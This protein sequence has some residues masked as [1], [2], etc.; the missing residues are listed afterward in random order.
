MKRDYYE[1]LGVKKNASIDEIKKAYRRMAHQHHPDK[2]GDSERFKEAKEA[3]EVLSDPQKRQ[4]Y[5]QFG[6]A[7]PFG[8]GFRTGPGFDASGFDFSGFD[9]GDIGGV[10]DI[11]DTF[12]GGARTKTQRAQRGA[13]LETSVTL[14]FKEAIFGVTKDLNLTK[15]ETCSKC[16][17]SGAEPGLGTKT[18]TACHGRGRVTKTRDTFL[19]RISQ[20]TTC[21]TC[22][23]KGEI[24]VKNCKE[25]KGQGRVRTTK[26]IKIKIPA[27]VDNGTTIRLAGQGEA[28][29]AGA[30]AGDLYLRIAVRPHDTLVRDGYNIKSQ[31]EIG[32]TDAVLGTTTKV[33]TVDGEVKLKIPAGTQPGKVFKLSGKGVPY[34]NS[35]RRGDHYVE[36]KVGIPTRLSRKQKELLE[37]FKKDEKNKGFWGIG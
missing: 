21:S 26:T 24:P 27:G 8:A 33:L 25:C 9:F 36:V 19:G 15:Y 6:H 32:L 18:C 14:D 2:G 22:R 10:G 1:V 17:G 12:F 35:S 16:K 4:Q 29:E 34:P 13:D 28:G 11:F 30:R 20:T 31:A 23:G 5:D 7:G 37:E 3:Y